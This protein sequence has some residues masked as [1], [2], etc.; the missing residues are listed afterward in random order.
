M[1][2]YRKVDPRMWGDAKFRR[3][4]H[5]AQRVWFY[6]LTG[7]ET[8]SLPGIIVAGPAALAEAIGLEPK[9]FREAFGEVLFQGMAKAD[10]EARLVWLPNSARYNIPESPNVV[11]S[12]RS[13]WDNVPECPLKVEAF[14][15]LQAFCEALGE[16]FAKAF[17]EGCA[18]PSPNQEQEQEQE[19]EQ[20][21]RE[22]PAATP[23][24]AP[25]PVRFED[26]VEGRV[27]AAF[28]S[29]RARVLGGKRGPELKL[30]KTRLAHLRAR[31]K[32]STEAELL[33][34]V[35]AL[36]SSEWHV[37]NGQTDPDLVFRSRERVEMLLSRQATS[38]GRSSEAEHQERKAAGHPTMQQLV[39]AEEREARRTAELFGHSPPP[40]LFKPRTT[41]PPKLQAAPPPAPPP[42]S[43]RAPETEAER[44]ARIAA[45]QAAAREALAAMGGT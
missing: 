6:L 10:T 26:S 32:D 15:E 24:A 5:D 33:G 41:A 8:T 28:R 45:A 21:K 31:A 1:S 27:W 16:G 37:A 22:G 2:R 14:R 42:K 20:N 18:Q 36:W 29:E 13:H 40:P 12:W 30:T 43:E 7:P 35:R 38:A 39:E 23:P 44:E 17:R 4:S 11:R 34:A 3:L 25:A 9:A 19:Q